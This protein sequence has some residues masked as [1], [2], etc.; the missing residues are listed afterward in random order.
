MLS[1]VIVTLTFLADVP[2]LEA[3]G[4]IFILNLSIYIRRNRNFTTFAITDRL[5]GALGYFVLLGARKTD[6]VKI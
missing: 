1:K 3:F 6:I 2:Y 5:W 4:D